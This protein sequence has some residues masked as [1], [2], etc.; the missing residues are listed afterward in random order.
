[1]SEI[2]KVA[3][4]GSGVMGANI[5]AHMAN[6]GVEVLLLD[7]VPEGAEDKNQLA[8]A[9]IKKYKKA[10]PK[11]LMHK[12]ALKRITAGNLED[13]LPK[14][15]ECDWVIEV[16]IEKLEIKQ[17]LYASIAPHL[18]ADA[19]LSSNTSTLPLA[20]LTEKLSPELQSRFVITHFFNP[21]RYMRL[22]ELVASDNTDQAVIDRITQFGDRRLGKGVVRCHDR[23]GFIA[24]RIGT[25]WL[26][27]AINQAVAQDIAPNVADAVLSRPIGVPKTGVFGL[28]DLIGIDLL[29]LIAT[30]YAEN[31]PK[32]DAFCQAYTE[33]AFI[34]EMIESGYT[35]RKGKGGFYRLKPDVDE[36]VKQVRNLATGEY[37][38]AGKVKLSNVKLAKKDL[39]GFFE[40]SHKSSHYAWE[41][42]RKVLTYAASL[43]GEIA[44]DIHSIDRAMKLGYNWKFGPFE[45]IDKLGNDSQ[46]GAAFL[47][48]ELE[49]AGEEVPA[50]LT[51]AGDDPLYEVQE[52]DVTMLGAGGVR[53][54]IS[55][56]SDAWMLADKKRGAKPVKR[57]ASASLWDIGD[58][59]LCLEYHSKMNTVDP[60]TFDMIEAAIELVPQGYKGLVVGNDADNFCAGANI[61]LGLFGANV[62]AY[63]MLEEF[64][65]RGQDL[66][67]GLKYAP[68]PVVAAPSGL[69]LGGGCELLLHADAVNAHA[70]L[71]TGLVEVGV[72]IVPGW[73]G[74]KEMILRQIAKRRTDGNAVAKL[75][76]MFSFIPFIKSFNI[77]AAI[78][79]AFQY[80]MTAQ[81]AKSA[82]E[83][84]DMLILNDASRITM[85]RERVLPDAK[86]L[87]LELAENYTAPEKAEV[88][89]P[90]ATARAAFKM[91]VN[92]FAKQGKATPHDVVIAEKLAWILSGGETKSSRMLSEQDIL[93]LERAMFMELLQHTDSLDR[94][95][96][97]LATGKP[98]RN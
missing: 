87:C 17:S 63:K 48:A 82:A 20:R 43:V 83:A 42:M 76:G 95:E 81:V 90:G 37:A 15:Q 44:D 86:A 57:N 10:D 67:M 54:I 22:L 31:L 60:L 1:M 61:G 19:V 18:K 32:D 96:H 40:H 47:A 68:F 94:I 52:A 30:S 27:E 38:D 45:L 23:P 24:N 53:N 77:M 26:T 66:Y 64:V 21:P 16:I 85:N 80:I 3:V 4:I 75:G 71:Y 35:G 62:A 89:L 51:A 34:K 59:I 69:A 5:A 13:D 97:M 65:K 33:H 9:A 25:Y 93:E 6:A 7:I 41:V 12:S 98:L 2:Q 56:S 55:T 14:L 84:R 46:S 29:P 28:M 11:P 92:N 49:K 88:S 79:P 73:G 36:K 58:G 8:N 39:R 50:I 70:E 74:C 91:A 72:G 78:T